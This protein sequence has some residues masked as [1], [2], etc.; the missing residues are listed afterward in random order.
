MSPLSPR[1]RVFPRLSLKPILP[2]AP[3]NVSVFRGKRRRK[4]RERR[5]GLKAKAK[6]K[7]VSPRHR[8]RRRH[9]SRERQKPLQ[10]STYNLFSIFHFLFPICLPSAVVWFFTVLRFLP[11]TAHRRLASNL[12][13]ISQFPVSKPPTG[14]S[15]SSVAQTFCRRHPYKK[16]V[17]S[18]TRNSAGVLYR[19][20]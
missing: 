16:I 19:S 6:P 10:S 20:R 7:P 4:R 3:R 8:A 9:A 13:P 1:H 12:F 14:P 2:P 15:P 11:P 5:C 18:P 17:V